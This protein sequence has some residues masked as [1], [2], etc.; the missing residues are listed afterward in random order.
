MKKLSFD[1]QLEH[2]PR[3][4]ARM[5]AARRSLEAGRGIPIEQVR[6]ELGLDAEPQWRTKRVAGRK[7]SR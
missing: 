2:D 1:D 5:E 7:H 4:I 3:F 6:V